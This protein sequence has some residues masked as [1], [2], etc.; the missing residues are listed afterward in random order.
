MGTVCVVLISYWGLRRLVPPLQPCQSSISRTVIGPDKRFK[1][2]VF[3]R[4]CGATTAFSTQ[5]SIAPANQE[6]SDLAGNVFIAELAD[7]G[8]EDK[9]GGPVVI[10]EWKSER[11]LQLTYYKS[12]RSYLKVARVGDISVTY[13]VK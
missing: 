6:L 9:L 3:E 8:T 13:E 1:A 11:S 10:L 2:V 5:V 12:A 4:D 7:S